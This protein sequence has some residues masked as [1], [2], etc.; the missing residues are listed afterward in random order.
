MQMND[1]M[2]KNSKQ[3][4]LIYERF[5]FVYKGK[6]YFLLTGKTY[7]LTADELKKAKQTAKKQNKKL[8][9]VIPYFCTQIA[10]IKYN[11]GQEIDIKNCGRLVGVTYS[12]KKR[13]KFGRLN[14][15]DIGLKDDSRIVIWKRRK[16]DSAVQVSTFAFDN[17]IKQKLVEKKKVSFTNKKLLQFKT[18]FTMK[19]NTSSY[20]LPQSMQTIDQGGDNTLYISSGREGESPLC[21]AECSAKKG[22]F[23]KKYMLHFGD[24]F[25][26]QKKKEIEGMHSKG[27]QLQFVIADIKPVKGKNSSGKKV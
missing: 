16:S 18:C 19:K 9:Q 10:C 7:K 17:K 1:I 11:A 27:S 8:S 23:R 22:E 4:R 3:R 25:P 12:N 14:R 26:I 15:V 24:N 2:N 13:T 21:I 6:E 20:I 5:K